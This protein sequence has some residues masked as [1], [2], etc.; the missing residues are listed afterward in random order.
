MKK[1]NG[2]NSI[3]FYRAISSIICIIETPSITNATLPVLGGS[4]TSKKIENLGKGYFHWWILEADDDPTISENTAKS[5]AK[6][7]PETMYN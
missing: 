2:V 4:A 5:T 3:P 7:I 1:L 6:D